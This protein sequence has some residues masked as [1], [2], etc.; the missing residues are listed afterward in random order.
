MARLESKL[1][2][3]MKRTY[4]ANDKNRDTLLI[5]IKL[6]QQPTR[7]LLVGMLLFAGI[8]IVSMAQD[9]IRYTKPAWRFGIAAGVN[10]N[11]HRG[12]TQQLQQGLIAPTA[13]HNGIGFGQFLA[14]VIE[15]APSDKWWGV[16][17][18]AG[19]DSRRGKFDQVKAPCNCPADLET[20]LSYITVE[21]SLRINPFKSRFYIYGGPRLAYNL[22]NG[23]TYQVGQNPDFPNQELQSPHN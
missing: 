18:Q 12:T 16:M 23:F 5:Q 11:F 15:Y 8:H 4:I 9:S 21:P 2:T 19:L 10:N 17:L 6:Q 14:P 13:F 22:T 3:K 1:K 7:K 20:D